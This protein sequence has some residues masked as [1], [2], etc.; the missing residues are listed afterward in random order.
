MD[1]VREMDRQG[2]ISVEVEHAVLAVLD[3]V[4]PRD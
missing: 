2:R 3:L 4:D 1:R